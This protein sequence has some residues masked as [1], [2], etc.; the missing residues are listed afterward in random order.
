MRAQADTPSR[1]RPRGPWK[2]SRPDAIANHL[3]IR[4]RARRNRAPGQ[5]ERP[6]R[7]PPAHDRAAPGRGD[8]QPRQRVPRG[9]PRSRR[10]QGRETAARPLRAMPRRKRCRRTGHPPAPDRNRRRRG[11]QR[12][13][14]NRKRSTIRVKRGTIRGRGANQAKYLHAIATHDINFGI[15]PAG[16]GKTFLAVAMRLEAFN[17]CACSA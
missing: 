15:G 16:T 5:P 1:E 8:R 17:A 7:W 4:P 12:R 10:R 14:S 2:T 9:G 11:R 3:R 6:V 13:R